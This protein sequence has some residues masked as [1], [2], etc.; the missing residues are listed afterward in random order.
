VDGAIVSDVKLRVLSLGAGVQSTTLALMAAAGEI[1][2]MPDAAIFADTGW[3]P[4]SVYRQLDWLSEQGRLPFPVH[5]VSAGD[6]KADILARRSTT[7]SRYAAVPWYTKNQDGTQ[8]IGLRQC[9]GQYKITPIKRKCRELLGVTIRDRIRRG[10]VEVWIG[11]SIDEVVR[12]KPAHQQWMT[13]RWP[14]IEKNMSR[15]ACKAWLEA[16]GFHEPPKSSCIGCP[17]HRDSVWIEMRKNS[18]IEWADAVAVDAALRQGNSRGI[19]GQEF[20]HD[21]RLPLPEAID[22]AE[23]D[24]REQPD[25]F[26]NECEGMC[27]V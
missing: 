26:A 21:S 15:R 6:I 20:M 13:N 22:L 25:L 19:R 17:F 14:L 1:G 8:G 23:R 3:E 7:G 24:K 11:I 16:R 27:G 10:S 4:A 2:P 12:M 9:T 5:I 18:P